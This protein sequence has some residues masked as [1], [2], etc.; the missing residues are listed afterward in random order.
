[1]SVS[2]CV[3]FFFA[4]SCK[5]KPEPPKNTTTADVEAC[6]M[7]FRELLQRRMYSEAIRLISYHTLNNYQDSS[8]N[9]AILRALLSN[10]IDDNDIRL[11]N[12]IISTT[13]IDRDSAIVLVGNNKYP[14]TFIFVRES[15]NWRIRF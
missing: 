15:L 6:Y 14:D 3:L 2:I 7:D 8:N 4:L 1:L 5:E 11:P 9:E 13:V 12:N 10:Y